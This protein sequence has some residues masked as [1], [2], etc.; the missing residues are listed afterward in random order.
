NY[1]GAYAQYSGVGANHGQI[2]VVANGISGLFDS[3]N[4]TRH[5]ELASAAGFAPSTFGFKYSQTSWFGNV[6]VIPYWSL[7][8]V[9]TTIGASSWLP[10]YFSLRALLIATTLAANGL[11][12]IVWLAR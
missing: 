4:W 5:T 3:S 12:L 11:G 9:A 10:W 2:I 7:V 8:V 6:L 1:A